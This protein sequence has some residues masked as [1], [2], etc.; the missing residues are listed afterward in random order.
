LLDTYVLDG[1]VR[2]V[3]VFQPSEEE[4]IQVYGWRYEDYRAEYDQLWLEGW[5]LKLLTIAQP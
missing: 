3:A 2:Y 1:E 5:R 4:E